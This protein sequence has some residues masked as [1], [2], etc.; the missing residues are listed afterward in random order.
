[1]FALDESRLREQHFHDVDSQS[2][3]FLALLGVGAESHTRFFWVRQKAGEE[4][5]HQWLSIGKKRKGQSDLST[6]S[7]V[8][9]LITRANREN[10]GA[11]D[12]FVSPNQFFDWRCRRSLAT[13]NANY[14]EIDTRD[15]KAVTDAQ[16]AQIR[17]EVLLRL[18][19]AKIPPPNAI[20]SSGSGGL[21]LYWCYKEQEAYRWRQ[22]QW[23]E[24]TDKIIAR[25]GEGTLWKVDYQA[26][27]DLTRVLRVP[28]SRHYSANRPVTA[29]ILSDRHYQFNSLLKSLS[30]DPQRPP[31]LTALAG[32][33]N[34]K[35]HKKT[36]LSASRLRQC[37]QVL[38]HNRLT[39]WQNVYQH[40][41]GHC[42]KGVNRG[43]RDYAAFILTV[44]FLNANHGNKER[45]V[46]ELK[47]CN[48]QFIH[49]PEKELLSYI[50]SAL[51]K[52]YIYRKTTL[53][54]YLVSNLNMN[55]DFL[56]ASVPVR[57]TPQERQIK[58]RQGAY[59]TANIKRQN[60]LN[61]LNEAIQTLN[62]LGQR[63]TQT[64][65]ASFAQLSV[66]Q[67][68]RYWSH[69]SLLTPDISLAS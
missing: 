11:C 17:K 66:R 60:A 16:A 27:R 43:Q 42:Q 35:A 39:W 6:L 18:K 3:A 25:L 8:D 15:H 59:M 53:A 24:L 2:K 61:R 48:Q 12:V 44:A 54:K 7:Q 26:S 38:N 22:K 49:L 21:H 33:K 50:S 36:P 64:N 29:D 68:R 65:I 62:A 47:T 51:T 14:I 40:I 58:Q 4:T 34:K 19:Q 13:L 10:E 69:L 56:F 41:K 55:V 1:M 52:G 9:S 46:A 45:T 37:R 31:H 30:I 57:L 67:V 20:V 28:G 23:S 5:H 63:L 32:S